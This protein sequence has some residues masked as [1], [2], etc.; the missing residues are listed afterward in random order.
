MIRDTHLLGHFYHVCVGH[1]D[2]E[3][4]EILIEDALERLPDIHTMVVA[5][6][7]DGKDIAQGTGC[8]LNTS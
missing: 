6:C 2:L 4:V 8:S 7:R 1:D 3:V 5:G